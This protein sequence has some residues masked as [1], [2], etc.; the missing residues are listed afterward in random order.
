MNNCYRNHLTCFKKLSE[1]LFYFK[2]YNNKGSTKSRMTTFKSSKLLNVKV[3]ATKQTEEKGNITDRRTY[4]AKGPWIR[5]IFTQS[6]SK[7]SLETYKKMYLDRQT[8]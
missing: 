2:K 5:R 1:L 7:F 8:V 4:L 6:F 3:K